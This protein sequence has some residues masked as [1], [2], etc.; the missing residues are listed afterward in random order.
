M[1]KYKDI[2]WRELNDLYTNKGY[3]TRDLA[4]HYNVGQTTIRRWLVKY[5]IKARTKDDG[6]QT[7]YFKN[8]LNLINNKISL[9][10]SQYYLNNNITE[11][12]ECP[13]C[14]T[15]FII[16]VNKSQK[17]CSKEC[18]GKAKRKLKRCIK[19]GAEIKRGQKYCPKCS[20][21]RRQE[22]A[23]EQSNKIIVKCSYC[24]KYLKRIPST[25]KE[26]CFCSIKCMSKYYSEHFSGE[27]SPTWKG[28][29]RDYKGNW[30]H[31]RRL[32]RERDNYTCQLCGITEN[33]LYRQLDVHHIRNYRLFDDKIK[34]NQI[35]N[36]ICLCN[37][38]HSFIHSKQNVNNLYL[39]NS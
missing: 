26:H 16:G 12:R 34:A 6:K 35:D 7:Q 29:K 25:I 15:K 19:C 9:S 2:D 27:N 4:K 3:S 14:H 39:N 13:I 18:S 32:A 30:E 11:L 28:G 24:G 31:S 22:I 20:K 33:E 8:K 37:K 23:K 21:E 1:S 36:L 5:N 38:C 10:L 17:Y